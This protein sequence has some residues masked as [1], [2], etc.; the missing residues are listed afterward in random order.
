IVVDGAAPAV[1]GGAGRVAAKS[2]VGDSQRRAAIGAII[3]DAAAAADHVG[4]A[5]RVAAKSAVGDSQR[6]GAAVAIVVNAAPTA[7]EIVADRAVIDCHRTM[8]VVNA[9]ARAGALT[10]IDRKSTRLNS[11]HLGISY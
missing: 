3:I 4:S 5:D 7:A 11:S 8:I 10:A 2:A 6:R 1:I 9:A